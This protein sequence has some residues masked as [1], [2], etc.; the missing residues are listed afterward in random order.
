M[1]R[2]RRFLQLVPALAL[3]LAVPASAELYT[4]KLTNGNSFDSRFPPRAASWNPNTVLIYS[5][6]GN[7]LH[8][9]RT[10]IA[11]VT[12]ET[13]SKGFG[14]VINT[15]TISLGISANDKSEEAAGGQGGPG[16]QGGGG[17]QGGAP[18]AEPYSQQQFVEPGQTS[19]IPSGL[20]GLPSSGSPAVGAPIVGSPTG[21]GA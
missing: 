14:T 3:A 5:D 10:D 9:A 6:W 7:W 4:I 16:G 20:I 13:Q 11:T 21:G 2:S 19:G 15:T 17:A 12:T 1:S 18:A 8:V